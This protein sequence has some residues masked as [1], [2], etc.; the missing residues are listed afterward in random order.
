MA[1]RARLEELLSNDL[2]DV[3][4][5]RSDRFWESD[6]GGGRV[7][8]DDLVTTRSRGRTIT[9]G[10][11]ML[12]DVVFVAVNLPRRRWWRRGG[13]TWRQWNDLNGPRGVAD[14]VEAWVTQQVV[15]R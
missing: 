12:D 11:D 13:S 8:V 4:Y 7:R 1:L 9:V 14:E 5:E 2:R 15:E 6:G 3:A 10:Y